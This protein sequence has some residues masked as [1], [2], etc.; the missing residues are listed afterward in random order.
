MEIYFWH[1]NIYWVNK[2]YLLT[3]Q[4]TGLYSYHIKPRSDLMPFK[5]NSD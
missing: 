3:S 5:Q 4:R 1:I 2:C